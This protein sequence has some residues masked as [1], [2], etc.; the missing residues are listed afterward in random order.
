MLSAKK[1]IVILIFVSW[2]S[3]AQKEKK[4]FLVFPIG[5]TYQGTHN[6]DFGFQPMILTDSKRN[7]NNISLGISGNL[8][9]VNN[10]TYL[11]PY[12]RLRYLQKVS[13][14]IGIE[15][16]V[17]YFYTNYN[18]VYDHR[19]VGEIGACYYTLH[20]TV[21]ANYPLKRYEDNYT[22]LLRVS[23]RYSTH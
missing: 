22:S 18:S 19:M 1:I 8:T 14:K 10:A 2:F 23:L 13:R 21:G 7:H 17:G 3:H 15:G 11:T 4:F 9:Y 16:S 20:L 12:V 5:Y 6:I